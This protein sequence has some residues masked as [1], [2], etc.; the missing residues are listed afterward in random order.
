MLS[1]LENSRKYDQDILDFQSLVGVFDIA[2]DVAPMSIGT[3]ETNYNNF[4]G[5]GINH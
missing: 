5:L 1:N 2:E 4:F 3:G